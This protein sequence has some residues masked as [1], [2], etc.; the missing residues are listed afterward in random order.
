M[1]V[2]FEGFFFL[3]KQEKTIFLRSHPKLILVVVDNTDNVVAC[4]GVLYRIGIRE[5]FKAIGL[6]VVKVQTGSG[7]ADPY[8]VFRI[9]KYGTALR[10]EIETTQTTAAGSTTMHQT[11]DILRHDKMVVNDSIFLPPAGYKKVGLMDLM[12]VP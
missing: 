5:T 4:Q 6:S 2:T 1:P 3:I 8:I 12:Q 9:A 7:G 10:T 11:I